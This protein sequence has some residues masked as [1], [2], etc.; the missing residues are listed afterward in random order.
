MR[1]R[2]FRTSLLGVGTSALG[3][4]HKA[5]RVQMVV[6]CVCG[7]IWTEGGFGVSGNKLSTVLK[8]QDN[9]N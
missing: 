8:L 9:V 1:S 2:V 4:E 6:V 3:V 5:G 7:Y